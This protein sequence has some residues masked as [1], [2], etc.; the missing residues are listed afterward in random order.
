MFPVNSQYI[1]TLDYFS[2]GEKRTP[3]ERM[4]HCVRWYLSAFHAGRRSSVAKK[5][6]NPILG[7]TFQCYYDVPG[8]QPC[9]VSSSQ[10]LK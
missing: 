7:E 9:A 2:I 4:V 5:P 8:E 3:R 10:C 1:A 6:Y